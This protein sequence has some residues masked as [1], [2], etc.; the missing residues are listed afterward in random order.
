MTISDWKKAFKQF[1]SRPVKL[2]KYIKHN[3]PKKRVC[4][5]VNCKCE[6]CGRYDGMISKYK[7]KLCRICFRE[8]APNVGFKK[9][10]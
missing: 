5:R 3:A 10:S 2:K 1:K 7:F 8:I 9:F 4:G 6:L